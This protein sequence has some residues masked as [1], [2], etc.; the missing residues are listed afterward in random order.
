MMLNENDF[1]FSALEQD[2]TGSNATGI[3][4]ELL[5]ADNGTD[6]YVV[7]YQDPFDAAVEYMAIT[8]AEK[9][10]L[11]CTPSAHLFLPSERFP[12][13][14]GIQYLP[15]LHKATSKEGLLKCVILN[16]LIQNGDKCEYTE[17]E[18]NRY[19]LDFGESFCFDFHNKTDEFLSQCRLA[20]TD[21]AIR[22][23]LLGILRIDF[24]RY[25][26][27]LGYVNEMNFL[28]TVNLL[29]ESLGLDGYT[30]ED[31]SKEWTH[32]W[33]RLRNLR[34]D[35]FDEMR[36]DLTVIYGGFFA[37]VCWSTIVNMQRAISATQ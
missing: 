7:K 30:R 33:R 26:H 4:G 3:S 28:D 24:D 20:D 31:V 21:K 23:R 27:D 14:I 13:A 12:H 37:N 35:A 9:L 2:R 19:T 6:K 1:S 15:D 10:R 25:M 11:H 32:V 8:L 29:C 18:G 16:S 22:D 36:D 17:S 34:D 5:L